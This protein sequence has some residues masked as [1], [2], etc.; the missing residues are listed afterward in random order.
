MVIIDGLAALCTQAGL[1][2]VAR[3]E[4]L[5]RVWVF[6]NTKREVAVDFEGCVEKFNSGERG[7]FEDSGYLHFWRAGVSFED[8][9]R[10]REKERG[11]IAEV[12]AATWRIMRVYSNIDGSNTNGEGVL[13]T[14]MGYRTD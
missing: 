4:L 3:G 10:G 9:R 8:V 6:A 5:E 2:K 7:V 13:Y 11:V 14:A 12:N 1:Q